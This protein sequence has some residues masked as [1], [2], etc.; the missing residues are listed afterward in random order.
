MNHRALVTGKDRSLPA[1]AACVGLEVLE[2]GYKAVSATRNRLFDRG[3][4]QP[5]SLGRPTLS[6]GNLTTGGTGKTPM[7]MELVARLLASGHHPAILL[8]GYHGHRLPPSPAP[9]AP[10][11][12]KARQSAPPAPRFTSDEAALYE[13]AFSTHAGPAFP[14]IAGAD[15]ITPV[16]V[17]ADPDRVRS[18]RWVLHH[19]PHV[20]A[21]VLDDG[22]QHRQ[23]ARD[24]D[25][26]LIDATLPLGGG[27][28]LPRGY[29]RESPAGLARADAV[30]V[31]RS[32][33]VTPQQLGIVDQI[34]I[35]R[36]GRPPLAHAAHVWTG[37]LDAD[38]QSHPIESLRT[39]PVAGLCGIGNPE[40]FK[41]SMASHF[42]RVTGQYELADHQAYTPALLAQL[43]TH[44]QR[45]GAAAMVTTEKD[46]VK[47]RELPPELPPGM[48]PK[49]S[50]NQ[51][52][53]PQA[54]PIYRPMLRLGFAEGDEPLMTFLKRLPRP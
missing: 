45:A 3:M 16:P 25:L 29:L 20:T 10:D 37:Y 19:H 27:H 36:H 30:I 14:R 17:A 15:R 22:F 52:A 40:A 41:R 35:A 18:A 23:V 6:V 34:V 12:P 38:N 50:P 24:L 26:V 42:D 5:V 46:W 21:F 2:V 54:F 13:Q 43:I 47:I 11:T 31:T 48:P 7:V 51:P 1:L 39:L 49:Q 44:A 4:R 53:P 32:D 33:Q 8:R 28:Q 9:E